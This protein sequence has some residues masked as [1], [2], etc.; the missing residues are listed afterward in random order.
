[1]EDKISPL[2]AK[3]LNKFT[4]PSWMGG[5]S[6]A[7]RAREEQRL[8]NNQALINDVNELAKAVEVTDPAQAKAMRDAANRP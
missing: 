1:L 3:L 4:L 6:A 2:D 8:K 7:D 5:Q